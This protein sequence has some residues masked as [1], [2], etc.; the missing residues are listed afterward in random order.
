MQLSLLFRGTYIMQNLTSYST[1][2]LQ[3]F[4]D[5]KLNMPDGAYR[6]VHGTEPQ[7]S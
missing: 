5:A 1:G 6:D 2:H 7:H 4:N 3:I